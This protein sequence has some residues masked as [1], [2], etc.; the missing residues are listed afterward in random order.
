MSSVVDHDG[1][2]SK[3][4]KPNTV[5]SE[6]RLPSESLSVSD[7]DPSGYTDSMEDERQHC[8]RMYLPRILAVDK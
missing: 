4:H 6:S 5:I 7:D 1:P 3:H 2:T 8:K